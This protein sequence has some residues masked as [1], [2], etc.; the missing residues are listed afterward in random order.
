VT[1]SRSASSSPAE[2][3]VTLV[4]RLLAPGMPGLAFAKIDG[5]PQRDLYVLVPPAGRHALAE[6][7]LQALIEVASATE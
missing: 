7:T 6:P 5:G 2:T 3:A 1:R 4:P